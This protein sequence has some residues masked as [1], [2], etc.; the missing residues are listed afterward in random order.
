MAV[1]RVRYQGSDKRLV[2][3]YEDKGEEMLAVTVQAVTQR[4]V[5]ARIQRQRWIPK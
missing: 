1:Q 5:Q 3:A 4:Q 2:V